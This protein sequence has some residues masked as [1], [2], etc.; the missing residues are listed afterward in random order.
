MSKLSTILLCIVVGLGSFGLGLIVNAPDQNVPAWVKNLPSEY[1]V[2]IETGEVS[3]TYL[4][5][6]DNRKISDDAIFLRVLSWVGL[7]GPEAAAQRQGIDITKTSAKA[8]DHDY[9]TVE[10]IVNWIVSSFWTVVLVAVILLILP[11]L[12]Y[13][14]PVVRPIYRFVA[15]LIP[16]SGWVEN[17]LGKKAVDDEKKVT[18]N[19]V[20]SVQ[21]AK[22]N[23]LTDPTIRESFNTEMSK[24]QDSKTKAVV[25]EIKS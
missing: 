4:Y 25:K 3:E 18:T 22:D 20:E 11:F 14:G 17:L 1:E 2:V 8:G 15:G 19:I 13:V 5:T 9:S 24:V 23:V 6:G 7:G 16:G 21:G 12:P 10:R